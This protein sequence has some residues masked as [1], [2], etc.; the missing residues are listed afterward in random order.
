MIEGTVFDLLASASEPRFDSVLMLGNNLGLL[1]TPDQ[2]P[3][4]LDALASMARPGARIVGE[5]LNPYATSNPDHLRYHEENRRLGRLAGQLRL[6][7]RHLQLATPWW[8]FLFCTPE[9]LEPILAPTAWALTETHPAVPAAP[10]SEVS[11][12]PGQW[13]AVLALRN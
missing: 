12:P 1:G 3:R 6:R 10:G 7:I 5:T 9:E 4:F 13:T 11:W 8:D 2:A